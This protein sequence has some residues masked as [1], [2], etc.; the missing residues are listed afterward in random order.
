MY[1]DLPANIETALKEIC[2]NVESTFPRNFARYDAGHEN[3]DGIEE[4]KYETFSWSKGDVIEMPAYRY[5]I[6]VAFPPST[7]QEAALQYILKMLKEGKLVKEDK[8]VEKG[9]LVEKFTIYG[10][11]GIC[12]IELEQKS[13]VEEARKME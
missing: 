2:Q 13:T 12:K 7:S 4:V 5:K 1:N 8:S 3:R 6:S 11:P 10:F 9:K